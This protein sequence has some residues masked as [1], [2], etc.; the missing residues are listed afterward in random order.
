[1]DKKV[2]VIL[3]IIALILAVASVAFTM[4]D[5]GKK[6]STN[7][8]QGSDSSVEQGKVGIE[9]IPSDIEDKGNLNENG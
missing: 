5:S 6:V 4:L 8:S 2:V 7:T 1:M 3:V 9:I